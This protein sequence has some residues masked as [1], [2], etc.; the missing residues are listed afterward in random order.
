MGGQSARQAVAA[1]L[2]PALHH[3]LVLGGLGGLCLVMAMFGEVALP[4]VEGDLFQGGWLIA[5]F[6]DLDRLLGELPLGIRDKGFHPLARHQSGGHKP[7]GHLPH[8]FPVPVCKI[9]GITSIALL[10]HAADRLAVHGNQAAPVQVVRY[11]LTGHIFYLFKDGLEGP[12]HGG[13]G[14]PVNQGERFNGF[15][16][17]RGHVL[18]GFAPVFG[19]G[20]ELLGHNVVK[21]LEVDGQGGG[22]DVGD[23]A[24]RLHLCGDGG[25]EL[26]VQE[27]SGPLVR[28]LVADPGGVLHRVQKAVDPLDAGH[29]GGAPRGV[30]KHFLAGLR[31]RGQLCAAV[32]QADGNAVVRHGRPALRQCGFAVF[33]LVKHSADVFPHLRG[34]GGKGSLKPGEALEK[35]HVHIAHLASG[36]DAGEFFEGILALRIGPIP[37]LFLGPV[38]ADSHLHLTQV[39]RGVDHLLLTGGQLWAVGGIFFINRRHSMYLLFQ[40][41]NVILLWDLGK[42]KPRFC[43]GTVNLE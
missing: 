30:L 26:V 12:V 4:G 40:L 3:P 35:P 15:G 13:G 39:G 8:V 27:V 43:T 32:D 24:H 18:G 38:H 11:L 31:R 25:F 14:V 5:A 17:I 42:E 19:V 21:I 34:T 1:H 9:L 23:G 20:A 37:Q 6:G 22:G 41:D 7:V 28:D 2:L 33:Q 36:V 10:H 16:E 29:F